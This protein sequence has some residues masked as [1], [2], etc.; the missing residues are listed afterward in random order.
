MRDAIVSAAMDAIGTPFRH[1]GR[2]AGRGMDCAG[3]YIHVCQ[4]LGLSY[5]DASGY[6]RN[7]YDGQLEKELDAQPQL[8]RISVA[9]AR[10]GDLLAM[11]MDRA[12]QHIAIHAGHFNGHP[13]VIHASEQHGKVCMHRLDQLWHARVMRAYR[14]E[15]AE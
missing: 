12:P 7:P 11:R 1:Q 3:L 6:P 9:E 14:F 15:G 5:Q 2:V 8:T 13:Y 4:L 10:K